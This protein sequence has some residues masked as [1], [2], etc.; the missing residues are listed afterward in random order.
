MHWL[1]AVVAGL[2]EW[3][4]DTEVYNMEA[5]A[6]VKELAVNISAFQAGVIPPPLAVVIDFTPTHILGVYSLVRK[7][8]AGKFG[9]G[10]LPHAFK[11]IFSGKIDAISDTFD[12]SE[13]SEIRWFAPEEINAMD[14]SALRDL[15]I[16]K[17]VRDYLSGTRY[18]LSLVTHT[19]REQ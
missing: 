11:I 8:S 3:E 9:E 12:T 17:E 15:D 10:S 6:L 7:D 5:G 18:P 13:I 4:A 1:C 19:V 16:K 2:I 14:K